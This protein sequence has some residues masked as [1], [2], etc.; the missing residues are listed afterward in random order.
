VREVSGAG[1]ILASLAGGPQLVLAGP[2]ERRRLESMAGVEVRVLAEGVRQN[3]L[4]R[5]S[6]R[7]GP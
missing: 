5:V 2:G 4:L 1:E 3:A 6:R 7:A